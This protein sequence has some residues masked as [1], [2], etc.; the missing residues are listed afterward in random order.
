MMWYQRLRKDPVMFNP[1][2]VFICNEFRSR[3]AS[4]QGSKIVYIT[5]RKLA[6]SVKIWLLFV[7]YICLSMHGQVKLA[8]EGEK[9]FPAHVGASNDTENVLKYTACNTFRS[10]ISYYKYIHN[11]I[12]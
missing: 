2:Y 6:S 1:C 4:N 3:N 9:V 11:Y 12:F 5:K 7:W 8:L 10:S